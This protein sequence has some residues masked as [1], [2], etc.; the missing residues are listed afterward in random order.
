MK[1]GI[2]LILDLSS[3]NRISD[4]IINHCFS[5]RPP[6]RP[7]GLLGTPKLP[8]IWIPG[9]VFYRGETAGV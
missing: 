9:P 7:E 3:A 4:A 1:S 8:S 2:A 6:Q 5:H